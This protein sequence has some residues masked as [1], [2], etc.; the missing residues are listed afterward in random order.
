LASIRSSLR[1]SKKPGFDP[2][3]YQERTVQVPRM[4]VDLLAVWSR[5]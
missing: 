1:V 4:L 5:G 3:N 2:K